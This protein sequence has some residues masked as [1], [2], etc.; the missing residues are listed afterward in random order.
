MNFFPEKGPIITQVCSIF[1]HI[2]STVCVVKR[3]GWIQNPQY[4]SSK[5]WE[6][7]IL[8]FQP[9]LPD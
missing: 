9:R 1:K 4:K 3:G 7:D 2:M 5:H 6:N 8:G